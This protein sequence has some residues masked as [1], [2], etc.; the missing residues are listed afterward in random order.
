MRTLIK[1]EFAAEGAQ[2]TAELRH[3]CQ[4]VA[5]FLLRR[6]SGCDKQTYDCCIYPPYGLVRPH[7]LRPTDISGLQRYIVTLTALGLAR[8]MI[9]SLFCPPHPH[10]SPP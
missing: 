5:M 2:N 6:S 4:T 9:N 3:A 1:R 7:H 8:V 10:S